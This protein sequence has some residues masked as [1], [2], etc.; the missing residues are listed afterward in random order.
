[1]FHTIRERVDDDGTSYECHDLAAI[2]SI[3]GIS[4]S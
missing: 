3:A 4:V 1:M 2:E